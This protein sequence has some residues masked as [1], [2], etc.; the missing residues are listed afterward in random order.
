[1][2]DKLNGRQLAL[3]AVALFV[4]MVTLT[5]PVAQLGEFVGRLLPGGGSDLA[6][7]N[8][9]KGLFVTSHF[10]AY[11]PF[12]F[13]WGALSD[14]RGKRKTILLIGLLGQGVMFFLMPF[15]GNIW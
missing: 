15:V 10:A 11:I 14:R 13:L 2:T 3:L 7:G 8:T 4:A 6:L 9:A 12:A 5:L 1:M